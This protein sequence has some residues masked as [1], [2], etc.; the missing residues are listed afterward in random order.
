MKL[1]FEFLRGFLYF[2]RQASCYI[3]GACAVIVLPAVCF[4]VVV[5]LLYFR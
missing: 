2:Q 4:A 3:V 1:L 5:W